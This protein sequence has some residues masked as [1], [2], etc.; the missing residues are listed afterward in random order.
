MWFVFLFYNYNELFM[1]HMNILRNSMAENIQ[2]ILLSQQTS[3]DALAIYLFYNIQSSRP[4]TIDN[5]LVANIDGS[6]F[7]SAGTIP[8][9]SFDTAVG[10][11]LTLSVS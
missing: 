2:V 6:Y 11:F 10:P 9:H 7:L 1:F 4:F 3:N 8:K 5:D